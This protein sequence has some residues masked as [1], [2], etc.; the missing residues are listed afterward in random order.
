MSAKVKSAL[1]RAIGAAYQSLIR[2]LVFRA[3][4][5]NAHDKA[6]RLLRALDGLPLATALAAAL[7]R[8]SFSGAAIKVGGL[9][10]SQPLIL[11]AGLVKGDGFADEEDALLAVN[12]GRNIMPGWRI[13]PALAGPVEFGSF[14]RFP[15]LGNP[16]T[17]V[18]RQEATQSTQNRVGLRNPGA[19]A[20]ARFLGERRSQLPKEFGINIAVS[21]GVEDINEQ[22]RQV[23]ESVAFFLNAG[24]LP[25]WFTLNLSCPNTEDDPQGHQLEAETSQLCGAFIDCLR[26]RELE[27]P[28]WVKISPGLAI[29]QYRRLMRL[30]DEVGVEA[31]IATNT[32]AKPSADDD[33]VQAGVGG[34]D[35]FPAA[36]DAVRQ[37]LAEKQRHGYAV[38][39]IAC[40]G[41]LD[42]A[43]FRQYLDLGVEA[44][45]YWSA[46]VYRGPFAAAI[47]E[48]ELA[49]HD[50]EY[51]TVQRE[52]L[53]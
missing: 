38:D 53:A 8:L 48:S 28:L 41:L 42:G 35:L 9:R 32:L 4:A 5:Q 13:V 47:I 23:V 2:P 12:Q 30:F 27:I 16:G 50:Y 11:A 25:T 1:L 17:V 19:H 24:V 26:A 45:Q 36:L 29:E 21:P 40:G 7:H 20:A 52:S 6:I 33:A 39:V 44:G 3:S 15:R 34:G 51:E 14:T 49:E 18:W 43:S 46:L 31:V 22:T 10:L 37:L